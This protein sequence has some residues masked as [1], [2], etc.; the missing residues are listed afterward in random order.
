MGDEVTHSGVWGKYSYSLGQFH[1][2]TDGFRENNDLE[3]NIYN[4][5]VQSRLSPKVGLQA[6]YRHRE[7]DHG[8]L[9]LHFDPNDVNRFFRRNL[10]TDTVR[11]GAH[12]APGPHSDFI[13]S[14]IYQDEQEDQESRTRDDRFDSHG[15][16][17]EAQYL[18]SVPQF[19]AVV[20]G[21]HYRLNQEIRPPIGIPPIGEFDVP[22]TNTYVYS[23]IRYPAQLTWSLGVSLDALD[24]GL[25]GEFNRLNPKF[26]MLWNLTPNTTLRLA[27]FR[28]LTRSLLTN[29]TIEPTQVAGFNQFFDDRA[30]TESKRYGIGLDHKFS[31]NLYSGLEISKRDLEVPLFLR[32]GLT[33]I[34][35]WDEEL[36]RAYLNWTPYPSLAVSVGY[37]LEQ[38]ERENENRFSDSFPR[39]IT[40]VAPVM[41]RFFHPSGFVSGVGATY[42]NQE[43]KFFTEAASGHGDFVLVDIGVAYRLPKRY[44]IISLDIRNL[45][46]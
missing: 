23:H 26:G 38:F 12:Y 27:A 32:R 29:Q 20:G 1:F 30:G 28:T 24:D 44:G 33:L 5:F 3:T 25:I 46:D 2:E 7:V 10:R 43:V 41:L 15:Y 4:V 36:Y 18:F 19:N 21:G 39:T 16:I 9:T 35:D 17:A 37:Q 40:H 11:V 45:L 31:S 6:E 13:V 14:A 22:H 8:D 34:D 42:V